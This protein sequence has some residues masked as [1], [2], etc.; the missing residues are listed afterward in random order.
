MP[1]RTAG[2]VAR[3]AHAAACAYG[4]SSL[5]FY[6]LV[7]LFPS[8]EHRKSTIENPTPAY[9]RSRNIPALRGAA[10]AALITLLIGIVEW[11]TDAWVADYGLDVTTMILMSLG[12]GFF[13]AARYFARTSIEIELEEERL[14]F[15]T[16]AELLTKKWRSVPYELF[17]T[18]GVIKAQKKLL[19]VSPMIVLLYHSP[20]RKMMAV[21]LTIP[22]THIDNPLE[23]FDA[24]AARIDVT[25]KEKKGELDTG[26][27]VQR[28][29]ARHTIELLGIAH[30]PRRRNE[31]ESSLVID[32]EAGSE[33]RTSTS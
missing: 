1:G 25:W 12:Y 15:R 24:L 5:F 33:D 4:A 13:S 20:K 31:L 2:A 3:R 27:T 29:E 7:L 22:L 11:V 26:V 23:L 28:S 19:R 14:R 10:L 18:A 6:S 16:G 30:P 8:F 9:F 17:H 32:E 21:Q